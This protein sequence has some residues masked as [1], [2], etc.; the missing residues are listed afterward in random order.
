[1][2]E[3]RHCNPAWLVLGRCF[4]EWNSLCESDRRRCC[5]SCCR[6]H[7]QP[8]PLEKKAPTYQS[9]TAT[10]LPPCHSN[11]MQFMRWSHDI[12]VASML[13]STLVLHV[14]GRITQV[15]CRLRLSSRVTLNVERGWIAQ[16]PTG[17]CWTVA[18]PNTIVGPEKWCQWNILG[19]CFLSSRFTVFYCLLYF[20]LGIIYR[21]VK[22][23]NILL[24]SEGHVVLTDFGLSKEFLPNEKVSG[25]FVCNWHC[26]SATIALLL[27]LGNHFRRMVNGK[28]VS[29]PIPQEFH[30][31]SIQP[32]STYGALVSKSGI[33]F[34]K[35]QIPRGSFGFCVVTFE[36]RFCCVIFI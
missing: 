29:P 3:N 30:K 31:K 18:S 12:G 36:K 33:A 2:V 4:Y 28:P 19:M 20:Q 23:E 16:I 22:L 25:V 26:T 34:A 35:H 32:S 10:F 15:L 24:D 5:H 27:V 1:M 9:D 14:C 6:G 13:I 21:D 11:A 7:Q 8:P 17:S